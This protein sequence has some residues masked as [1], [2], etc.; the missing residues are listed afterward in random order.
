MVPTD[1][2]FTAPLLKGIGKIIWKLLNILPIFTRSR[3]HLSSNDVNGIMSIVNLFLPWS[4]QRLRLWSQQFPC[5]TGINF[6]QH[7]FGKISD[8]TLQWMQILP[9]SVVSHWPHFN[10]GNAVQVQ[11][12]SEPYFPSP[13][14]LRLRAAELGCAS[15]SCNSR[16]TSQICCLGISP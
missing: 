10:Q 16:N 15:P 5:I 9:H 1:S 13:A 3:W 14:L 2:T 7:N 6:L 12:V 11:R 4:T 8:F